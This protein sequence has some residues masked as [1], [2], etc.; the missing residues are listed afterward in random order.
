M[1]RAIVTSLVLLCAATG[2]A[3]AQNYAAKMNFEG[4]QAVIIDN[5]SAYLTLS[6][7]KFENSFRNSSIRLTTNLSWTNRSTQPIIAFE[8]VILRYDPFNRPIPGGGTWL[9]TGKNSGDWGALLPDASSS[10]GLIGFDDEPVMTSVVYVRAIRFEDGTV[11]MA[12]TNEVTK[13]I[14]TKLPQLREL[15]DVSPKAQPPK[16]Q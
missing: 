16:Q 5:A 4:R 9:I 11:W 3:S 15:G 12:N 13:L 10:D 1:F 6:D 14:Q 8:V 2:A 7:F